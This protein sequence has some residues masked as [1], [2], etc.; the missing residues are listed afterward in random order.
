MTPN[1]LTR[2]NVILLICLLITVLFYPMLSVHRVIIKDI[3]F[4]AIVFSGI[5][6]L[7]FSK[8][9]TKHPDLLWSGYNIINLAGGFYCQ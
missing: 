7:R 8:K 5:F 2:N 6:S 9:N 4:S 1:K 3:I